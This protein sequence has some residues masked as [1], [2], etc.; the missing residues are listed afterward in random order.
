M[1]RDQSFLHLLGYCP[2][3]TLTESLVS[4]DQFLAD[5]SENALR[6]SDRG[7]F[8]IAAQIWATSSHTK[9]F[10]GGSPNSVLDIGL[11]EDSATSRSISRPTGDELSICVHCNLS[12]WAS[13]FTT[14]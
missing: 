5:I 3:S 10:L 6:Q 1:Q 2:L 11:L 8:L 12:K 4:V 14:M 13:W 7:C 9:H